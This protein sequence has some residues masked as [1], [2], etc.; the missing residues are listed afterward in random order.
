MKTR[1]IVLSAGLSALLAGCGTV[2]A[3]A[4]PSKAAT[5]T[6]A[7]AEI[8]ANRTAQIIKVGDPATFVLTAISASGRPVADARV[9]WYIGPVSSKSTHPSH[10]YKATSPKGRLL[11][12]KISTA[13]NG[14]GQAILTLAPQQTPQKEMISVKIGALSTYNAS[15]G[16]GEGM[17]DAWWAATSSSLT[18]PIGNYVMVRPWVKIVPPGS[19]QTFLAFAHSPHGQIYEAHVTIQKESPV[20]ASPPPSQKIGP[21]DLIT[22]SLGRAYFHAQASSSPHVAIP[23][24]INVSQGAG[25]VTGGF[26]AEIISG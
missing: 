13:T 21:V 4:V 7:V 2:A 1:I 14:R 24:H 18:T 11:V 12:Q 3:G 19:P 16:Q 9:H 23:L 20:T 26:S 6:Q 10:W 22:N 8:D 25:H 17:L 15:A 5:T